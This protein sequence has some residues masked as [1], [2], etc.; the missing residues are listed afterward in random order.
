MSNI[1]TKK[2][3]ALSVIIFGSIQV[4]S[5]LSTLVRSKVAAI[6]VGLQGV[7]LMAL[8][9]SIAQF[10]AQFTNLGIQDSS[11]QVLSSIYNEEDNAM[12]LRKAVSV[13][14][15]W[16]LITATGSML[17][18]ILFSPLI[19]YVYF[20][21]PTSHLHS[22]MLLCL[23][24]A[25]LIVTSFETSVMKSLQKVK[26]ITA[27]TTLSSVVAMIVAIPLFV[28]MGM[29][30]IV[31]IVTG[32]TLSVAVITSFFG[33][34]A[35]NAKP[36]LQFLGKLRQLWQESRQM[37]IMGSAFIATGIASMGSDLLLQTYFNTISSIGIV[38]IYKVAYQLSILYP[39]MIFTAV[40]Y[41]YFPRLSSFSNDTNSR[42]I[43]VR[44]QIKVLLLIVTPCILAFI[45]LMPWI[46]PIL[47]SD[48]F[49][50]VVP[51]VRI[52]CLV[53]IVRCIS[54][55]ICFLPMAMG[56]PRDFL[57]VE[58]VSYISMIVCVIGGVKMIGLIGIGYGFI[59]AWI[60][61][62]IYCYYLSRKKY[63]LRIFHNP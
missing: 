8:Y 19:A 14:R 5:I 6:T 61:E 50:E 15:L 27:A 48:E 11:V 7:G 37:I 18:M 51:I 38:G 34:R 2:R 42:N 41:D 21:S 36:A 24:P 30:G 13:I 10:I 4:I 32:S 47:L 17:V 31:F 60:I 26:Y 35:C 3:L 54:M 9:T 56:R 20:G 43:L 46:V 63:G 55:P 49:L 58:I 62:M 40:N 53:T 44:K 1:P 39:G 59:V 33:Y 57:Q 52:G 23:A 29:D 45:V 22:I 16:E 25:S 28:I 12:K